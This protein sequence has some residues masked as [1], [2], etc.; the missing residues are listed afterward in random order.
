[1]EDDYLKPYREILKSAFPIN[2]EGDDLEPLMSLIYINFS[3]RSLAR[4][5]S[6]AFGEDYHD[7]L[8]LAYG[9]D[10]GRDSTDR[11]RE[12]CRILKDAGWTWP[13]DE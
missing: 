5:V 12:I 10:G 13:M 4:L 7:M 3:K 2:P 6:K 1:M 9:I 8:N 11:R